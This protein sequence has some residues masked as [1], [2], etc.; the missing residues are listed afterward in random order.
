MVSGLTF[1]DS[2]VFKIKGCLPGLS[3]DASLF[4]VKFIFWFVFISVVLLLDWGNKLLLTIEV[5][6]F[7]YGRSVTALT[8]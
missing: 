8:K 6:T 1:V 7:W 2:V 3:K 4:S 5:S